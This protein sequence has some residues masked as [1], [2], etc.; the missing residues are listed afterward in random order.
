M[1]ALNF[2]MTEL[3]PKHE[4][5]ERATECVEVVLK[6]WESWEEQAF[7]VQAEASPVVNESAVHAINHKGRYFNVRGPLQTPRSLRS[8]LEGLQTF[9]RPPGSDA[10]CNDAVRGAQ[11]GTFP[12]QATCRSSGLSVFNFEILHKNPRCGPDP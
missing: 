12:R 8:A 5:Y 9:D 1:A 7:T 3:P 4:R 6:L 2:G 10:G 11:V